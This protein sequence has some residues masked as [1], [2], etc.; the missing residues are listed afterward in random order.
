MRSNRLRVFECATIA[1][2]GGN[3]GR[4]KRVVAN[5]GKD[6]PLRRGGGLGVRLRFG[7]GRR[8]V[9]PTWNEAAGLL[10]ASSRQR[11]QRPDEPLTIRIRSS[12]ATAAQKA[13]E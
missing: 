7:R 8:V 13:S 11:D 10:T 5:R 6:R 9:S 3:A 4:P 12:S 1:K 2:I